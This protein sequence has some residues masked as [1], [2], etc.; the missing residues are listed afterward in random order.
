[1]RMTKAG[2]GLLLVTLSVACGSEPAPNEGSAEPGVSTPPSGSEA[3][4]AGDGFGDKENA[5]AGACTAE[6][7]DIYVMSND[8]VLYRFNPGDLSFKRVGQFD[9]IGPK[10]PNFFNAG[11]DYYFRGMA[12][13]RTGHGWLSMMRAVDSLGAAVTQ[14]TAAAV[15]QA[16]VEFNAN[17]A[18]CK[19][20]EYE[21]IM[22]FAEFSECGLVFLG[23]AGYVSSKCEE[24]G[25]RVVAN[26]SY[27]SPSELTKE[28]LYGTKDYSLISIDPAA[29]QRS[30]VGALSEDK[31]RYSGGLTG[32]GDGR[33]YELSAVKKEGE[34]RKW[35]FSVALRERATAAVID[36]TVMDFDSIKM[37][38][39]A[40]T[41]WGGDLW[42][43]GVPRTEDGGADKKA[44]SVAQYNTT[45]KTLSTVIPSVGDAIDPSAKSDWTVILGAAN[46]TCAPLTSP[47]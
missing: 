37:W 19:V 15:D 11:A 21:K 26:L 8:F 44:V 16:L 23:T 22:S 31:K 14:P 25:A 38:P 28:S 13:D 40:M 47:K 6:S 20:H 9:C 36:T 34:R 1:M 39:S 30:A 12:I 7:K 43:F 29:K 10:N 41:F 27:A 2:M 45:T 35:T 33:L 4:P 42:F 32:T 17:D 3:A 18:T 46:S 24:I 5:P